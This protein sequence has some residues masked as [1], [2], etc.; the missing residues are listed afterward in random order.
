[1]YDMPGDVLTYKVV[2]IGD[3]K[4]GKTSI[5]ARWVSDDFS[6]FYEPTVSPEYTIK[7]VPLEGGSVR[8]QVWDMGFAEAETST[9]FP[10]YVAGASGALLL[11]DSSDPVSV[12]SLSRWYE[13]AKSLTSPKCVFLAVACK[14]DLQAHGVDQKAR[15]FCDS[16]RAQHLETSAKRGQANHLFEAIARALAQPS[17]YV[18]PEPSQQILAVPQHDTSG[19]AQSVK[20]VLLGEPGVGKSTLAQMLGGIQDAFGRLHSNSWS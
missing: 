1:V 10:Q 20:L 2:L 16:I 12:D 11:Y 8:L 15:S 19:P 13:Q 7:D 5:V 9:Q 14:V 3:A 4:V 17:V 6:E 18:A